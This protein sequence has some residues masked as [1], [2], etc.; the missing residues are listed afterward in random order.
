[1][2]NDLGPLSL[3]SF[4]YKSHVDE[5]LCSFEGPGAVDRHLGRASSTLA[6]ASLEDEAAQ[7]AFLHGGQGGA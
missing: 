4:G 7:V 6:E 3:Q 5:F 2:A 1:M